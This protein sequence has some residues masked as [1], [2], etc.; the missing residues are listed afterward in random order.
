MKLLLV[1]ILQKISVLIQ[2]EIQSFHWSN[3]S[4]VLHP[5][6]INYKQDGKLQHFNYCFITPYLKHDVNAIYT[7]QKKVIKDLKGRLPQLRKI[8]FFSDGCGEQY[9]NKYNFLNICHHEKDFQIQYEWNFYATSRGRNPCDGIS[10]TLKGC[11]YKHSLRSDKTGFILNAEQFHQHVSENC[12]NIKSIFVSA[13]D[14]HA[15]TTFLENRF[16]VA[17]TLKGTKVIP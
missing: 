16:N 17:K 6:F 7:F 9:K 8:H 13:I 11:A 14:I 15:S 3:I 1:V 12:P 4:I 10:G 5:M 2:D